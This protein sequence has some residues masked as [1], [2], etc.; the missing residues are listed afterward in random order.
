MKAEVTL[1]HVHLETQLK[2]SEQSVQ[3]LIVENPGEY[4]N[5]VTEIDCALNDGESNFIFCKAGE[6]INPAKYGAIITDIF[7]FDLNDKKIL[8]LLQKRLENITYQEKFTLFNQLNTQT[9]SF[10]SEVAFCLPFSLDYDELSPIDFFKASGIKFEK[11]YSSLEEKIICYINALIE[12]KNC[13][14]FIFV[15]LKSVLSDEK[16]KQ[17]YS[18]CQAEQVGLLLIE[19]SKQRPLLPCEKAVII[20]EDLCEIL[21]NY[22]EI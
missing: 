1:T 10:L 19:N 15:N 18:H 8:N 20:T 2:I 22:N 11:T 21:E 6:V 5:L 17:I 13:E 4:F 9:L 7:H 3:L 12:L 14:F 16:I